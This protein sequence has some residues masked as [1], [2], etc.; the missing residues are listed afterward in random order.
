[1]FPYA[2]WIG[3]FNS[4]IFNIAHMKRETEKG[5]IKEAQEKDNEY[6]STNQPSLV[7]TNDR[8]NKK[9][10]HAQETV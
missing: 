3:H 5:E 2:W 9:H 8:I 7:E 10:T 6:L 1:M 4:S